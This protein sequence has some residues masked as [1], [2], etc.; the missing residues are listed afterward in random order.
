MEIKIKNLKYKDLF[1]DLN[2]DI[3]KGV[4]TSIIGNSGSGKTTLLNLIYG[5]DLNFE[6]AI[7]I[8]KKAIKKGI[9]KSELKKIREKISYL[10]QDYQNDLFNDMVLENIRSNFEKG[11]NDRL[12][13]LLKLFELDYNNLKKKYEDLSSGEIRKILII[14]ELIA[15]NKIILLDDPTGGLDQKGISSLIKILKREKTNGKIIIVTS[16]DGEFLFKISDEI[17]VIED[18]KATKQ[19]NKYKLFS[20]KSLLARLGINIPTIVDFKLCAYNRKEVRLM[21]RDNINDL[22]KDIYRN[23]VK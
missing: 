10:T 2:I 12:N 4:I 1:D 19:I 15:N 14:K 18:G 13:D 5:L 11:G 17:I 16:C 23:A 8:G 21:D 20:N 7:N 9:K 3:N 22:I 6:G